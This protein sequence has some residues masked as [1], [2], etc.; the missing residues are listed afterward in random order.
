VTHEVWALTG[1]ESV[2]KR[3]EELVRAADREAVLI[4]DRGEALTDE[5]AG[6]LETKLE[7]GVDVVVGAATVALQERLKER[8]PAVEV[9]VSGL[10]WLNSPVD[11][12]NDRTTISRLLLVDRET[13]LVSSVYQGERDE[14]EKAVF[15]QGFENGIVVVARRILAMG[16]SQE[17]DPGRSE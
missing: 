12:A 1:T 5:L 13:V 11:D 2:E 15:G 16:L 7:A 9:F 3:T 8:L 6:L 14:V 10:E 4:V 17:V